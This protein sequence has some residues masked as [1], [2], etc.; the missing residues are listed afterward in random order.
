MNPNHGKDYIN[1][2]S[3]GLAFLTMGAADAH[4]RGMAALRQRNEEIQQNA[5][6]D[7]VDEL[8]KDA[9]ELGQLSIRLANELKAEREKNELLTQALEQR[10]RILNAMRSN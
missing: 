10:Q 7:A 2:V 1:G 9:Q 3:L 5:Y 6:Y 8:K 4:E